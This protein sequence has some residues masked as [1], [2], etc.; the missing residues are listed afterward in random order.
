M[1]ETQ[2]FA[3]LDRLGDLFG[4]QPGWWLFDPEA[5]D[6]PPHT[7]T[8]YDGPVVSGET[9]DGVAVGVSEPGSQATAA[10]PVSRSGPNG[11]GPSDQESWRIGCGISVIVGDGDHRQTRARLGALFSQCSAAIRA[12]M[13]LGGTVMHVR[14][15]DWSMWQLASPRGSE[16]YLHFDVVGFSQL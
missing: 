4:A 10:V 7:V 6:P 16:L 12:D 14:I 3:A 5:T 15:G 8:V 13:T 9:G 11:L 2:V 1:T